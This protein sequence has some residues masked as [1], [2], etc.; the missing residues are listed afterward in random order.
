MTVLLLSAGL[1]YSVVEGSGGRFESFS[2][3]QRLHVLTPG[4]FGVACA[5]TFHLVLKCSHASLCFTVWW[6]FVYAVMYGLDYGCR[7]KLQIPSP[8]NHV[9]VWRYFR[10]LSLLCTQWSS[11]TSSIQL[12]TNVL[13]AITQ[14]HGLI[15]IGSVI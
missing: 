4:W 12:A 2:V 11:A 8:Y 5:L 7:S 6:K 1:L 13:P 14:R 15:G 10:I 9:N 3:R